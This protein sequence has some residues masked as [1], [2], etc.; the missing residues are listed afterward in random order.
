MNDL[1]YFVLEVVFER[2]METVTLPFLGQTG[3]MGA[4]K[5]LVGREDSV[6][7]EL[8]LLHL[9]PCVGQPAIPAQT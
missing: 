2:D 6:L 8:E 9:H 4:L 5:A 1:Q 7:S 3:F